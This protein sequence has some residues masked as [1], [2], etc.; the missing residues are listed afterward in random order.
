M[1]SG[2]RG[3]VISL[4]FAALS[5]GAIYLALLINR[6]FSA[7]D[8]PSVLESVI[9]RTV[10]DVSIPRRAK[11]ETNPLLPTP[12]NVEKGRNDYDERCVSCHGKVDGG[13]PPIG[14][15][16]YPKAPN[17]ALPAT[18][19]LSD[20]EIHYIIRNG[21]RLTGM[22]A[23]RNP[24]VEQDDQSWLL[25]LYIRS[26][27]QLTPEEKAQQAKLISDSGSN[28]GAH[29]VGSA[30][31]QKRRWPTSCAIRANIPRPSLPIWRRIM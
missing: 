8:K 16:I 24:H 6:G 28:N 1:D 29:Y 12:E 9:A 31:C 23:W 27:A 10:R 2:K 13:Q 22:P 4:V 14:E 30:A 3:V 20:G 7:A 11:V 17:L 15:N 5:V 26:L 21:V 25:V 18:Q 19:Q